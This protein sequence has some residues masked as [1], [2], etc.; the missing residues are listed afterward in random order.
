MAWIILRDYANIT[1]EEVKEYCKGR[2][3]K[4]KIPKH[5]TFTKEYP[6]TASGKI[7]KFK[8]K[9]QAIQSITAQK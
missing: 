5:I 6:M 3:S 2:I 8:L 4:H 9:E 1:A 7:Q